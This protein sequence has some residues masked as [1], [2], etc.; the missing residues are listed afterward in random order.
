MSQRKQITLDDLTS[1]LKAVYGQNVEVPLLIFRHWAAQNQDISQATPEV[2]RELEE[3]YLKTY[4]ATPP[5]EGS[6]ALD[7]LNAYGKHFYK[8]ASREERAVLAVA[9]GYTPLEYEIMCEGFSLRELMQALKAFEA[10]RSPAPEDML[11]AFFGR[12]IR[13]YL[14]RRQLITKLPQLIV[15]YRREPAMESIERAKA[16]LKAFG[17]RLLHTDNPEDMQIW[18]VAS[19]ARDH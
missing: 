3:S 9:T 15:Q 6:K 14:G 19:G 10:Q 1:A 11:I 13:E 16:I 18:K 8:T 5:L 17:V 7:V 2:I 12:Y 4:H